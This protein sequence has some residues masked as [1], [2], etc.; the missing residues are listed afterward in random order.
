MQA[1]LQHKTGPTCLVLSRQNLPGYW[2]SEQ[3]LQQ[4]KRGGY[5]LQ[6]CVDFPDALIIATGSEVEIAV[7][8]AD[9]L[10]QQGIRI[11]VVSMPCV[12][13]FLQQDKAYRSSILPDTVK[14]R[15]IVEAGTRE[16]WYQFIGRRGRIVGLNSYGLSAPA[17]DIY[18]ELGITVDAVV[19]AVSKSLTT[20]GDLACQLT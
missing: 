9:R 7:A 1:A 12:D 15:V 17:K 10:M 16:Y 2:R 5:I 20:N 4:I 18:A 6:D 14:A 11:R 13:V 8:A 3:M 19:E